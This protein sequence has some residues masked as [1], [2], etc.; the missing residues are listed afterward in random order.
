[1]AC[2]KLP[3]LSNMQMEDKRTPK[4]EAAPAL[5]ILEPWMF[6]L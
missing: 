4:A 1:M 5:F 3:V 2:W 6:S